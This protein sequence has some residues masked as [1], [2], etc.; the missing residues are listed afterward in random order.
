MR[1]SGFYFLRSSSL[2]LITSPE[3]RQAAKGSTKSVVMEITETDLDSI[4]QGGATAVQ[5]IVKRELGLSIPTLTASTGV[6]R[7]FSV[8]VISSAVTKTLDRP[9]NP[10]NPGIDAERLNARSTAQQRTLDIAKARQEEL[11]MQSLTLSDMI[12]PRTVPQKTDAQRA[13]WYVGRLGRFQAQLYESAERNNIPMQLL[14][15]IIINELADIDFG[16]VVQDSPSTFSGSLGIAQIQIDTALKDRLV[17]VDASQAAEGYRRAG[18]HA[19]GPFTPEMVE[20]GK[21]LRAGQLL[22]IPQVA[23]EAAAQEIAILLRKAGANQKQPWQQ[24]H[25]FKATGP[26]GNAIYSQV[27]TG[28]QMDR[29]GELASLVGG[30]YNSPDIIITSDLSRYND[31]GLPHASNARGYAKD[32]F[33]AGLFR[34]M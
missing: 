23:I 22:Q 14:A 15:T 28:S 13:A 19:H 18:L 3:V 4:R 26:Q 10:S 5:A 1:I 30:A 2:S 16:D 11:P 29:E 9:T 33:K 21:R 32:L 31:R 17:D 20:M 27:G 8:A 12:D 25:L 7:D 24:A 6:N 34:A